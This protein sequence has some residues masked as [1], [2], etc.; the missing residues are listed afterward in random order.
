MAGVSK[1]T[2]SRVLSGKG[3]A[4]HIATATEVRVRAVA[5]QL[6]YQPNLIARNMALGLGGSLTRS[7]TPI[8]PVMASSEAAPVSEI[9][10]TPPPQP[11][12]VIPAVAVIEPVAGAEPAGAAGGAESGSGNP[13]P[14]SSPSRGEEESAS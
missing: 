11:E 10:V 13:S 12:P 1:S 3:K 8:I 6:G 4:C 9:M 2:V 5:S 14:Q 7:N